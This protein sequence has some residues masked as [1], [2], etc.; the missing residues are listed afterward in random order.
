MWAETHAIY[1][2]NGECRV[3]QVADDSCVPTPVEVG[4]HHRFM[5]ACGQ[6]SVRGFTVRSGVVEPDS[7]SLVVEEE[8]AATFPVLLGVDAATSAF[9]PS[10]LPQSVACHPG[11]TGDLKR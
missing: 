9:T 2:V 10:E 3:V 6:D 8:W 4:L 1:Q 7:P 11:V 5:G